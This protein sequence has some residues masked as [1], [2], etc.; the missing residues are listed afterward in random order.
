MVDVL[1]NKRAATRL[2]ILVEIAERQPAVSQGEIA[3][4]VGVTSQAVSEYIRELVDDGLVEKEARSRYHV[5]NEGVDWLF[6]AADDVRRFA[7]HVTEDVLGAVSEDAA[8]ATDEV[9]EGESVTLSIED[10]LL[11]ATSGERGSATGVATTD[12]APGTDVGVT[13]FEGVIDLDPGSV[14]VLQVPPVRA[15]G[16]RAVDEDAIAS[17]VDG[18]DLVLAGGVEAVVTLRAADAEPAVTVA[19]GDVAVA[20]AERGLDVAVVATIDAVG[21]VTDVLRDGDVPY[22][23]LEG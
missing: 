11:H 18:A 13:G 3:D 22:E 10:G 8:I 5:T 2:R 20:A 15:G 9:A 7:D 14:T 12:A 4:E 23:V 17:A 6:R 16:S 19:A 21:R 1:D